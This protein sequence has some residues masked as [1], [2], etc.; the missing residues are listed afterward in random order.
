MRRM[1]YAIETVDVCFVVDDDS[2][3][4]DNKRNIEKLAKEQL[5]NERN[6]YVPGR[7]KVVESKSLTDVPKSWWDSTYWGENP[8]DSTVLEFLQDPE[9][10][11]YLRL[12]AKFE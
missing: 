6:N 12:K 2:N 3:D 11:E 1:F 9:Y 10:K 4:V 7:F 5:E 8:H